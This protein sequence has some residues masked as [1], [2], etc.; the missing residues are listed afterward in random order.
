M[1]MTKT[2]SLGVVA[3]QYA[4]GYQGSSIEVA[5]FSPSR[6]S[7]SAYWQLVCTIPTRKSQ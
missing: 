5:M 7:G 2:A 6:P 1:Y 3:L 4:V